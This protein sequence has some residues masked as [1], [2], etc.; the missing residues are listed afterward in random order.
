MSDNL[1][2]RLV[3][4]SAIGLCCVLSACSGSANKSSSPST[5]SRVSSNSSAP[6]TPTG[7]SEASGKPS[8]D[9]AMPATTVPN[10]TGFSS[11]EK[12]STS[13]SAKAGKGC[14]P[15]SL[16][17]PSVSIAESVRPLG[18]NSQGQIYPPKR[19]T[20]WY[21]G[22]P[23]PGAKGV[24][25]IAGHISYDGPDNFY[26]L[27]KVKQGAAVTVRCDGG[28]T[29]SFKVQRIASTLKTKLQT[30]QSVWGPS[31]TPMVALITCDPR[32]PIVNG[33]HLNN[34]VAWATSS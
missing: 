33:H 31:S 2:H 23:E 14:I 22:S 3:A 19:T 7:S 1:Q 11:P 20:M 8:S 10:P 12:P 9:A 32:S 25:V 34:F 16:D 18:L 4:L 15:S 21:S 30:D 5:A 26:N 13:G 6:A 29:V 28:K 27:V 17:V 24:S